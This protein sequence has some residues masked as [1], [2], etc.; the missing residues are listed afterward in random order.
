MFEGV[1]EQF[2]GELDEIA[3]GGPRQARAGDRLGAGSPRDARRRRARCS[4]SAP[5]TT[6]GSPTT[7]RCWPRPAT[8]SASAATAW[9]RCASSAARRTS[10]ASSR[11]GISAFL[12]TRGHDPLRLVLR[13]QRGLFE[14]LLGE[15]DAIISDALNHASIIDG[16]RL[17]KAR[18]LRY[19]N[20]DI[21]ELETRLREA[22]DARRRLIATDGVFSMDG[23][24]APLPR[25]CELAEQYDAMVMVDD[26]HAVGLHGPGRSRDAGAARRRRRASTSSPARSARRSAA[27][28]AAS[29][30]GAARRSRCCGSARARTS[31]PTPSRRRSWR[32]AWPCSTCW[33]T[34]APPCASGCSAHTRALPARARRRSASTS[35]RASTRSCPVMFGDAHRAAA[36]AERLLE[37]GV[38]AV[39]FSYPV[40]PHGPGAHPHPALRGALRRGRRPRDR[41]VRRGR[42]GLRGA[43]GALGAIRRERHAAQ[44]RVGVL[45]AADAHGRAQQAVGEEREVA[46]E[47]QLDRE[48]GD[49]RHAPRPRC[50]ATSRRRTRRRTRAASRTRSARRSAAR[51]RAARTRPSRRARCRGR[52]RSP[53]RPGSSASPCGDPAAG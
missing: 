50:R 14:T 5:T 16:V 41:R 12:G 45:G 37:H 32:R 9:R 27:R 35:C 21:D 53:P 31:S 48:R 49:E 20:G 38:Y 34:R 13:R 24:V 1:R 28:A 10:T 15:Q 18:R 22:S 44:R 8:R 33:R 51:A 29:R 40:V 2:Q 23:Y 52:C 30:A 47:R 19:A 6:S 46:R 43:A 26:S 36:A 11:S 3:R 4:T 7:R 39:A 42:Y 25:I 17:C